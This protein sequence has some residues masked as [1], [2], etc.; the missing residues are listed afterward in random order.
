MPIDL[1]NAL[2]GEPLIDVPVS[3]LIEKL[4]VAASAAQFSLDRLSVKMAALLSEAMVEVPNES[5]GSDTKSLLELGFAPVFYGVDEITLAVALTV[6]LRVGDVLDSAGKPTGERLTALYGTLVTAE[7]RKFGFEAA[8]AGRLTAKIT[9]QPAPQALLVQI[10]A[11][12][13]TP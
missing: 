6:A 13:P 1:S 3:D 8:L 7:S 5:G 12:T 4:G 10:G 11:P 9:A 2:D